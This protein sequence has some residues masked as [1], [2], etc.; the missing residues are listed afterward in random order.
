MYKE[1]VNNLKLQ[2]S[3]EEYQLF[4][5]SNIHL[6]IFTEPCL[7]YMLNGKKTLDYITLRGIL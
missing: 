3:N 5:N 7:T 4:K 2:L 6:G 1:I